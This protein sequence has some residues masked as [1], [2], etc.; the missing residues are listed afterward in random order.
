MRSDDDKVETPHRHSATSDMGME[1]NSKKKTGRGENA[2]GEVEGRKEG[3]NEVL[4]SSSP[5]TLQ[6]LDLLLE[7]AFILFL[8]GLS[9]GRIHL[10]QK[11]ERRKHRVC[12]R[13][14]STEKHMNQ[15]CT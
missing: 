2:D 15:A 3:R 7:V 8:L 6:L 10:Q 14:T 4:M 12:G 11:E 13:E 1:S 5:K 9:G